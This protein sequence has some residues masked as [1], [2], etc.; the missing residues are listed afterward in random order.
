M[1]YREVAKDARGRRIEKMIFYLKIISAVI[2]ERPYRGSGFSIDTIRS[3]AAC[4][5]LL[6][7][8]SVIAPQFVGGHS[9]QAIA[10]IDTARDLLSPLKPVHDIGLDDKRPA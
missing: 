3:E 5:G 10:A 2:P 1:V 7:N 4:Q 6:R 8:R 9:D